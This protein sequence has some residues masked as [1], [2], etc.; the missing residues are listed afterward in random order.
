VIRR[1][2]SDVGFFRAVVVGSAL[3][4]VYLLTGDSL[5]DRTYETLFERGSI[6]HATVFLAF[7]A[8]AILFFK[9]FGLR[10]QRQVF[11]QHV[12]PDAESRITPDNVG[13]VI[14]HVE[15]LRAQRAARR[16]PPSFL[17]ERVH[18]VL[19]HYQARGVVSESAAVSQAEGDADALGLGS[20]F[21][22]LKVL[23]WA[24]PI[25][26][27][28]GTVVGIGDAVVGF[29]A[30]IEGAEQIATI[31]SSLGDVTAGLAVAFD[32][33][34]V[35]L[36]ASIVV[37]MPMSWLQKAEEHLLADVDDYCVT[38]VLRR[39][40]TPQVEDG[41]QPVMERPAAAAQPV[42]AEPVVA[43]PVPAAPVEGRGEAP[44]RADV[45][46]LR[47]A[48]LA[49]RDQLSAF[50]VASRQI[51]PNVEHAVTQL[52]RATVI[53][54]RSTAAMGKAEHQLCQELGASRQLL[55]LLAAGIG[56]AP[57]PAPIAADAPAA[58]HGSNGVAAEEPSGATAAE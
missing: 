9:A 40:G 35:A 6:P 33:T 23:I 56:H 30:S 18:R 1:A 7:L 53:A 24:I 17:L 54:E 19:Q 11:A 55:Q 58:V 15:A 16:A 22:L 13:A 12:L 28:I 42:A 43:A 21:S 29:S 8:I 3:F 51:G 50:V 57:T 32:T 26:G 44:D 48:I 20:S 27:F 46:G 34:L 39:L 31:K 4:G 25:L 36:V 38:Q 14:Q 47:E 41:P 45:E 10:S 52:K 37:M 2:S 5:P 49:L